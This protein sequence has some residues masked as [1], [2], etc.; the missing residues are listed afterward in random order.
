MLTQNIVETIDFQAGGWAGTFTAVA[1]EGS[2]P[3]AFLRLDTTGNILTNLDVLNTP[4]VLNAGTVQLS[5]RYEAASMVNVGYVADC[6]VNASWL[7]AGQPVGRDILTITDFLN[8]PDILAAA[9]SAF[10]KVWVE[11]AT[12]NAATNDMFAGPD[13]FADPDFFDSGI[14]WG[15]W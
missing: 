9:S 14:Q 12:A 1:K 6:S 4:D 15:P 10:V 2:D 7:S 13:M 8:A 11:I 5:G 3:A